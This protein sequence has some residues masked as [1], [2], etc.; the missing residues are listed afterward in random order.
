MDT[1][2]ENTSAQLHGIGRP[3][4]NTA[5]GAL[6]QANLVTLKPGLNQVDAKDWLLAKQQV[7][8]Q[9]HLDEGTFKELKEVDSLTRL[10]PSESEKYID[11]CVDQ[12]LLTGWVE[13]EKR[14]KIKKLLTSRIEELEKPEPGTSKPENVKGGK[15]S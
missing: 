3:T 13:I 1:L 11:L 7:M 6:V 10:S 9:K 8:V 12:K 14:T 15:G 4:G 5:A 2:V